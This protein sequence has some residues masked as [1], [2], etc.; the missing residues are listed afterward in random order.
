MVITTGGSLA[1]VLQP[2]KAYFDSLYPGGVKYARDLAPTMPIALA[3]TDTTG[4]PTTNPYGWYPE[5][6]GTDTLG[7]QAVTK[8][9]ILK[10]IRGDA[11]DYNTGNDTFMIWTPTGA[12]PTPEL[13]YSFHFTTRWSA[14]VGGVTGT[15][16]ALQ[17]I[18]TPERRMGL[19]W[20]HA[21]EYQPNWTGTAGRAEFDWTNPAHR[22]AGH[23]EMTNA[24]AAGATFIGLDALGHG[25][26][27]HPTDPSITD[28]LNQLWYILPWIQELKATYPN[29]KF[30]SEL[31]SSD[32]LH[33]QV[34]GFIQYWW[35]TSTH[36]RGRHLLADILLP[37]NEIMASL[38][39][40]HAV[41]AE[42]GLWNGLPYY[43]A[44][45]A[46]V[47]VSA[48][49]T[50]IDFGYV[51]CVFFGD[52]SLKNDL[53]HNQVVYN[54]AA[55]GT[56]SGTASQSVSYGAHSVAVT[57]TPNTG[58]HFVNWSDGATA[59]P[60][61]DI[62]VTSNLNF[63]ANFAINTYTLTYTVGANGSIT[64]T[65]PQTVNHGSNGSA[66]TAVP[67]TGYHFVNWSDSSTANPR[68]DTGVTGNVS[69]TA[70]F[71]AAP[72]PAAPTNVVATPGNAQVILTW[73]VSANATSY[74]VKRSTVSGGSY[75]T[76]ASPTSANY[77]NTGLT[78][79]TTY[80]YV[81]SA[82]NAGGESANSS[83]V[84]ATPSA[85]V[86]S[87]WVTADIGAV[88]AIGAASY[89][90]GTNIVVGSGADIGGTADEFRYVYQ[91][92]SGKCG[93]RARV[94]SLENT[95]ASAKAGVMIRESTAAGSK[96]AAVVITPSNG[97]IFQRRTSTNGSTTSTTVTG[98][99]AP[100]Y[101]RIQ[102]ASSNSFRA[103]YSS[104]G[105]T[106]TQIGSNTTITMTSSARIGMVVSS[107][108]D[109]V[110]CRSKM[111]T[112]TATP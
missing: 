89:A 24:I 31:M 108:N 7:Y 79:G 19:W 21:S 6:V 11:G 112:I 15:V 71:I 61:R 13:N 16:A 34:A 14:F 77:T 5:F 47:R 50:A 84:Y 73:N 36:I 53:G 25:L 32:I 65:T 41:T 87:P 28:G 22:A 98:V 83:Q 92:S 12:T 57:A 35:G 60:R 80:Y 63:T 105:S 38:A 94:A 99:T 97:V 20:G 102:R 45:N 78:N 101:V 27:V 59:N 30:I 74:N 3:A 100:R 82:V 106:W 43:H 96:Y 110:L 103:Y 55:N 81:V 1:E 48:V 107:H 52:M 51:P 69:V 64:G 91:T 23:A 54:A 37:G 39:F 46:A 9:E 67:D 2:Y 26:G 42:P 95:D 33:Q 86:P 40:N 109:G 68:T 4:Y 88:G 49:K 90:N 104:N 44:S 10:Y 85:G 17:S 72:P 58:Y 75:T 18:V 70:N 76:I 29:V 111:D 66:V 62:A 56:I 93:M 8:P